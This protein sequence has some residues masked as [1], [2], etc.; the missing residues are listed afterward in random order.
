MSGG[1]WICRASSAW[2]GAARTADAARVVILDEADEMLSF[3]FAEDMEQ[4][5]DAVKESREP[6]V[7][8]FSATIPPW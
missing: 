7:M 5:L 3:G 8:M 2:H 1:R 6:Q 4:L